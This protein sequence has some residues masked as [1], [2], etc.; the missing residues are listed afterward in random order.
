MYHHTKLNFGKNRIYEMFKIKFKIKII[1]NKEKLDN[2]FLK[3]GWIGN[4]NVKKKRKNWFI[5]K[6]IKI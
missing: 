3:K 1:Y 2:V 5:K 4:Q 6:T